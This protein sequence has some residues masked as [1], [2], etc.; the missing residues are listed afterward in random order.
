MEREPKL[1]PTL[2][3]CRQQ[4][5]SYSYACHCTPL[6][7]RLPPPLPPPA[8][9]TIAVAAADPRLTRPD[10]R[11]PCTPPHASQRAYGTCTIRLGTN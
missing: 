3:V 8:L 5:V 10:P 6:P 7:D 9:T 4:S 11:R 2:T 1:L